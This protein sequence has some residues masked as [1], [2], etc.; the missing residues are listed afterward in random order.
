MISSPV[1]HTDCLLPPSR[2]NPLYAG[3]LDPSTIR[4]LLQEDFAQVGDSNTT[5]PLTRDYV[6]IDI[7]KISE[8]LA[9]GVP[10]LKKGARFKA[11]A[12]PL[13]V[14]EPLILQG[15]NDKNKLRIQVTGTGHASLQPTPPSHHR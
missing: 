1:H 9:D 7:R 2:P 6:L 15:A 8:R 3:D 5:L 10:E 14:T 4:A 11:A 13:A 12:L